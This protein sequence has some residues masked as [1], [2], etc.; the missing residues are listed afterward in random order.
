[1]QH[2]TGSL[3]NFKESQL[4]DAGNEQSGSF[5]NIQVAYSGPITSVDYDK[6]DLDQK[7][8]FLKNFPNLE[9]LYIQE[10]EI[11]SVEFTKYLPNLRKLD[12][13]N[14]Y[15]TDLRPL[16]ELPNLDT[17]WCAENS[18]SQGLDL[19]ENVIVVTE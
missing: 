4:K 10:N 6:I 7:I 13:T 17:V 14:N 19:G 9:E 2:R 15:V 16:A 18:I 3:Q 1:M 8:S 12:I 5:E 11:T